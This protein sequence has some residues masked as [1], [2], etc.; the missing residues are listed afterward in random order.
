MT[1]QLLVARNERANPEYEQVWHPYQGSEPNDEAPE[2]FF[3]VEPP[4]KT[5]RTFKSPLD[6]RGRGRRPRKKKTP[7]GP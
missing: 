3:P 6:P 1:V 5:V 4:P 2:P 7:P